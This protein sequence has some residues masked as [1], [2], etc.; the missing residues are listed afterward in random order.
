L[1]QVIRDQHEFHTTQSRIP[2]AV[3]ATEARGRQRLS[4][5]ITPN[6]DE[7]I[8]IPETQLRDLW[9]YIRRVGYVLPQNLPAGLE[10]YSDYILTLLGELPSMRPIQL[11]TV[12]SETV[13]GLHYIPPID[14]KGDGHIIEL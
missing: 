13:T 5:K 4:V 14:H 8:F 12:N 7:S 2:F 10:E 3:V 6:R 1:L 11:A 9:Q